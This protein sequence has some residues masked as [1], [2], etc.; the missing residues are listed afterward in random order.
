[1]PMRVNGDALKNLRE[2]SGW[3]PSEFAR[4]VE[5]SPQYLSD[6]ES[7]RKPGSDPVILRMAKLLKLPV[8][9]IIE[10][11]REVRR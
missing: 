7:G 6:I 11:P 10:D 9:A 8:G 1:M 2:R 5:I 3:R 4:E